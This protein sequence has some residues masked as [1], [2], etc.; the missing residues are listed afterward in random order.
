MVKSL[1]GAQREKQATWGKSLFFYI[2]QTSW[3]VLKAAYWFVP[4]LKAMQWCKWK[5]VK[6]QYWLFF[7]FFFS[8][9]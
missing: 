8:F 9:F 5:C 6:S 7:F 4:R 3:A 2:E 1:P